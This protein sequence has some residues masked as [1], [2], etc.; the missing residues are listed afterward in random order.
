M[1]STPSYGTF[2]ND[3]VVNTSG[4]LR[5]PPRATIASRLA[6]SGTLNVVD[7]YV[8]ADFTGDWSDFTGQINIGP[9]SGSSEFRIVNSFGYG[10]AALFLSNGVT[11]YPTA[12]SA[13]VEI[14]ELA[15][16]SGSMLGPGNGNGANPT[17]LIGG[18]NTA[19]TFAGQIK[20]ADV[21]TAV[22]TGSGVW[23][24][25]GANS[26]TGGMIVS[27]GTL[28]VNNTT[29]SGTGSGAVEVLPGAT[30]GGSG[31]IAG[32]VTIEADGTLSPGSSIGRLTFSNTLTLAEASITVIE[33][34]QALGTNDAV[35]CGG[36]VSFDGELVVTNLAGT[37]AAGDAFPIFSAASYS[38]DFVAIIGSPGPSLEWRFNPTNGVLSVIS[39]APPTAPTFDSF[40]ISG[41]LPTFV[42]GGV[43]GY[44]YTIQA[45]T[46]LVAW[47]NL[48]TTN[49]AAM[50]FGWTDSSAT[51]FNR[52]FYRALV[53]P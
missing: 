19:A 8:R 30:L 18:K 7:D 40:A 49:P 12:G 44:H 3:L 15:G 4:T 32:A 28:L 37:L 13:T 17:W 6:G 51:N 25:T 14:G 39:T 11:A 29:G 46:N 42:I 41:G 27:N 22:K 1:S 21:T 26:F 23:T 33:I 45:S 35:V 34:N 48:V 10:A 52:R 24:L 2:A 16:A 43:P 5:V 50:P 38:G 47:T 20:D 53:S 36:S 9:R 31:V